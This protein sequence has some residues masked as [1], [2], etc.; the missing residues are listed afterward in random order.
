MA[1]YCAFRS[2]AGLLNYQR[3]PRE[4]VVVIVVIES[5]VL[6]VLSWLILVDAEASPAP[7]VETASEAFL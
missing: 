2:S 6:D 1:K 5:C 4:R 7:P 3:V